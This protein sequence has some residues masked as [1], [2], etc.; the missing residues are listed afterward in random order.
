MMDNKHSN[1]PQGYKYSSLGIIP[2][3]WEVKRMGE[4]FS[5]KNGINASKENYGQ[6]VKFVNTMDVLNNSFIETDKLPGSVVVTERQKKE[7]LVAYGDVLFN[8]TSETREEVGCSSV[9]ID[10]QEAVFGGFIIRAHG[11]NNQLYTEYKRYCFKAKCIRNQIT[12]FGNGAIR[13]N[14]GQ[15]DLAKVEIALPP[16]FEQQ[17]IAEIL[18]TWDGAIE[19]QYKL[20][21]ALIRRKRGLM[22]QLL[23]GKKQLKGFNEKWETV[24]AG[25]IFKNVS[26][27]GKNDEQLLSATQDHGVI[28]RDML[29]VRVTM[30]TGETDSFKLVEQGDFVISLR[31]FQGGIEYSYYRGIV[32]PAYTVLKPKEKINKEFYKEYFKSG[33]FIGHLAVAVIGIRDGKQIS[34][35]DFCFI[36]IPYP[37]IEEQTAIAKIITAADREIHIG[38]QKLTLLHAQKRGLMQELLTGKK[39]V[40]L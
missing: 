26:I 38:K 15:E 8:R 2:K 35:N 17:K 27:K 11:L 31:S 34:Y 16:L 39:R 4:L 29:E 1:I 13:Y 30:P 25:T 40:R 9:F 23:T 33:D 24:K 12:A 7:F 6:G 21:D 5:F 22:Q 28:P 18:S 37:S 36:K 32:S 14:L 19:Q 3:E 10:N 20:I